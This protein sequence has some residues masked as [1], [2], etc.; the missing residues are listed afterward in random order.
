MIIFS[1]QVNYNVELEH[2]AIFYKLLGLSVQ[3]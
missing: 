3:V 2:V 1:Y